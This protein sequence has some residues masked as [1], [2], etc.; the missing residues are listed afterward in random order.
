MKAIN[1]VKKVF[2]SL[3]TYASLSFIIFFLP[4]LQTCSDRK[5]SEN[6]DKKEKKERYFELKKQHTFSVYRLSYDTIRGLTNETSKNNLLFVAHLL[7]PL[8][9]LNSIFIFVCS[10]LKKYSLTYWLTIVSLLLLF[11]KLGMMI[12]E[13]MIENINQLKIGW[14][15]FLL[16]SLFILYLSY[17]KGFKETK[18]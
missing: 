7:I 17:Q 6:L 12:S 9:V 13:E 11:S 15:L 2:V 18:S 4:F 8:I 5:L 10:F 14:Y 1:L 3:K 16:N